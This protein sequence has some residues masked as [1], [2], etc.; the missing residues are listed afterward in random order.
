MVIISVVM[1]LFKVRVHWSLVT[2]ACWEAQAQNG[3]HSISFCSIK[4]QYLVKILP[5]ARC[6]YLDESECTCVCL[7][8]NA[9]V[10]INCRKRMWLCLHISILCIFFFSAVGGGKGASNIKNEWKKGGLGGKAPHPRSQSIL[11]PEKEMEIIFVTPPA[12]PP[13]SSTDS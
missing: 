13:P 9:T 1:I 6:L 10:C 4:Y 11:M 12:P 2:Y 3:F 7:W 8:I 5:I